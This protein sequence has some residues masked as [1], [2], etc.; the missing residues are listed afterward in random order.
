MYSHRIVLQIDFDLEAGKRPV[1]V[2]K[3]VKLR[4]FIAY[5][6]AVVGYRAPG[7]E[8]PIQNQFW[9]Y[10]DTDLLCS[11]IL[12]GVLQRCASRTGA[13]SA[14]PGMRSCSKPRPRVAWTAACRSATRYRHNPSQIYST[15]IIP[16]GSEEF[17]CFFCMGY[18]DALDAVCCL[19][20]HRLPA[21]Q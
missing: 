14:S 2:Q 7:A 6:R 17:R 1:V 9:N 8:T 16:Q 10:T 20:L 12:Y 21:R 15:R 11:W 18:A 4:G 13:R 5:E 3:P 19:G